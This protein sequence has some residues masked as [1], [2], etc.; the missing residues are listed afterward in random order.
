MLKIRDGYELVIDEKM[1]EWITGVPNGGYRFH[2]RKTDDKELQKMY[3][4]YMTST[5][6]DYISVYKKCFSEEDPIAFI[7]HFILLVF[8]CLF[9]MNTY[10]SITPKLLPILKSVYMRCPKKWNWCGFLYEWMVGRDGKKG[11]AS[12]FIILVIIFF[13][14]YIF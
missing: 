4:E 6:I 14:S 11:R 3:D 8:G 10:N 12:A 9:C 7:R 2:K 13:Y 1:I 5:G